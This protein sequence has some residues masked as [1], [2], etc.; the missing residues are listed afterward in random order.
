MT[1]NVINIFDSFFFWALSLDFLFR[2]ICNHF[3]C[4]RSIQ[5]SYNF[6][7]YVFTLLLHMSYII[8]VFFL[9]AIFFLSALLHHRIERFF[10]VFLIVWM[11]VSG[12]V[13]YIFHSSMIICYGNCFH[14]VVRN[15]HYT[16]CNASKK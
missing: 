1:S 8:T 12:L 15:E 13:A 14:T 4:S 7:T 6:G 3:T 9:S 2:D 10:S 11:P 5:T 16:V